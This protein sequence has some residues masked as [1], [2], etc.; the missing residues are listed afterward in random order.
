M[1]GKDQ[2]QKSLEQ[3]LDPLGKLSSFEYF[4]HT[5]EACVDSIVEKAKKKP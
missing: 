5:H 1:S 3:F 4:S 2:E